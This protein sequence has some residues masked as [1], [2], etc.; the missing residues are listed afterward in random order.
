M[1]TER[2]SDAVRSLD[3]RLD[4]LRR[5]STWRGI[6]SVLDERPAIVAPPRT[7]RLPVFALAAIAVVIAL[8]VL[9][10]PERSSEKA[11]APTATAPTATAPMA[12]APMAMDAI[13]LS[14][15]AGQHTVF[16]RDGLTLTLVG[17]SLARL[18][19]EPDAVRVNV[20]RGLLVADRAPNAPALA[21]DAGDNH[22]VSRD[23][24]FAVRVEPTMVVLGAGEQARQIVERHAIDMGAL[25]LPEPA[26]STLSPPPTSTSPTTNSPTTNSQ[27]TPET[28]KAKPRV[29]T[30]PDAERRPP[31]SP[32]VHMDAAELYK[33]AEA[34]LAIRDP[35]T[36]RDFLERLLAEYPTDAR[37]D[38]ARYD[39][40]LIARSFGLRQRALELLDALIANGTDENLKA[41][42]R[43]LR[44]SLEA[45]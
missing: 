45:P 23:A 43:R 14:A 21:V 15:G 24:R 38:A 20:T 19:R 33:R 10:K 2:V 8:L 27:M 4:D 17:P 31:A 44:P 22:V 29:A 41:A 3:A 16:E 39:L 42:A 34:A 35:A 6:E 40:A 11:V 13:T 32:D 18:T 36:A 25:P 30:T 5:E 12:T 28:P 9:P 1:T 26:S 7:W 37:V